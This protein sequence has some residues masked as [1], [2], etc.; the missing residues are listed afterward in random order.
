VRGDGGVGIDLVAAG[1]GVFGVGG[2]GLWGQRGE[3][4]ERM[5]AILLDGGGSTVRGFAEEAE[6][7]SVRGR[8]EGVDR[9][10]LR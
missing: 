8:P 4:V 5:A 1:V 10:G 2:G 9:R 7:R 3:L 6:D